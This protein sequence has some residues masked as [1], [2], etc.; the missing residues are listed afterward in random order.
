M[1]HYGPIYALQRNPFFPKNFLSVGDWCAR[2][3]SE[4]CKE[5]AIMWTHY[6]TQSLT[7][8][9]WS[10]VR[11]GVF[12]TSRSDGVLDVWD[13]T[14]K[15]KEPTLSLKVYDDAMQCLRMQDS[16]KVM[17]CGSQ[18]GSI[19]LLE[20]SESFWCQNKN[21]RAVVNALYE[22]ETR[23]EKI[24]ETRHR[25]M[26]LKEKLHSSGGAEE[27][28]ETGHQEDDEES[29][30]HLIKKARE[31]FRAIMEQE[32]EAR[33]KVQQARKEKSE[34]MKNSA[35]DMAKQNEEPETTQEA[36]TTKSN[37]E[38]IEPEKTEPEEPTQEERSQ[39]EPAE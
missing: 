34:T 17:A 6:H 33:N 4:D 32:M 12:Y 36:V 35:K 31:N 14:F 11:P 22:R 28:T 7:D 16:G 1:C 9:C 15:Q 25:E 5:S 39:A 18:G 2:I 13:I 19:S 27:P 21:E 10:P 37:Q 26:K 20:F 30:E 24:L 29:E 8:G 23:R 3:W 38:K